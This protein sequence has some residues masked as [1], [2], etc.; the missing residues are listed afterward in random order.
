DEL[1]LAPAGGGLPIA[2]DPDVGADAGVVEHVGGQ[3]DDGFDEVVLQH[4]APDLALAAARAAGEEGRAIEDDAE[5][6]PTVPRGAHLR[7]ERQQEEQRSVTDPRQAGTEAAVVALLLVLLADLFLDLL[8]LDTEGRI[9][10]H[11]IEVLPW[12]A[13]GGEGVA[14]DDVRDVLPFD[15]HV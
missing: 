5:A 3:A 14:E 10:E 15:E 2:D 6:A 13:I 1:D 8:P 12:Q 4:M 11:V 7:E 9:R